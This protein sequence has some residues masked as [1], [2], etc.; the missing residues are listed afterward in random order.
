MQ[1]VWFGIFIPSSQF[2]SYDGNS[3]FDEPTAIH[4]HYVTSLGVFDGSPFAL[5]GY[6][7]SNKEVEHFKT[8]WRSI[9]QFPFVSSYVYSYSTVTLENILYIFGKC[10]SYISMLYWIYNNIKKYYIAHYWSLDKIILWFYLSGFSIRDFC[11]FEIVILFY[12]GGYESPNYLNLAAKYDGSW[13]RIGSLLQGRYG[14]RSI[15]RENKILHI[16][17]IGE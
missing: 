12:L 5:G 3:V 10:D 6:N 13:E 9:G 14:H 4:Q 7:P 17:G 8:A 11:H 1:K 2:F 15:V 16:G